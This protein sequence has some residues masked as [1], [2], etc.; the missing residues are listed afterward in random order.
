MRTGKTC[1]GKKQQNQ[2]RKK[3]NRRNINSPKKFVAN[4][5]I[6]LDEKQIAL[7]DLPNKMCSVIY[8]K[9]ESQYIKFWDVV[10]NEFSARR[11][12]VH[13]TLYYISH[14]ESLYRCA[15]VSMHS[16]HMA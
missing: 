7:S 1:S 11:T 14:L 12:R 8:L 10:H 2:A 4:Q 13:C 5:Y 3:N 9:G 16:S 15:C 6:L